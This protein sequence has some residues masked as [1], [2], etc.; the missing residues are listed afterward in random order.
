MKDRATGLFL[1]HLDRNFRTI[2]LGQVSLVFQTC[3][4]G[5][6]ADFVRVAEFVEI[7]Q[8]RRERFAARVALAFILVTV[9][10]TIPYSTPFI[11]ARAA[12]RLSIS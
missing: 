6:V 1:G 12:G 10:I 8:F 2:A 7:E 4:H 5:T 3:R 11:A 9:T